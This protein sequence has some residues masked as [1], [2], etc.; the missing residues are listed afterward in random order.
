MDTLTDNTAQTTDVAKELPL[1]AELKAM[2]KPQ[3]I[4]Y[5]SERMG[6]NVDDSL[7]K[8]V[9]IENLIRVDAAKKNEAKQMNAE[10]LAVAVTD[11]DPVIKVKF[12]NMESPGTFIEFS[13]S[14]KRGMRGPQNPNGFKKCPK[15][16]LFHGETYDIPYSVFEHLGKLVHQSHKPIFDQATGMQA[17]SMPILKPRFV[18][19]AIVSKEQLI[20]LNS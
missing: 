16:M 3:L 12:F 9:I 18:L 4:K 10:S 2:G 7:N 11:K 8:D 5:A 14:G 20:K 15:Y 1:L 19:Q 13:Y 17:G 6:L